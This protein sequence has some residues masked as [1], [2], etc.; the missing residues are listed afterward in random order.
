MDSDKNVVPEGVQNEKPEPTADSAKTQDKNT[1]AIGSPAK[2]QDK[3]I[4]PKDR[5]LLTYGVN[6][7]VDGGYDPALAVKCR[8]GT[9]VG[10]M[11]DGV[12]CFRGIPFA[13]PPTDERRWHKPVPVPDD[14]GVYEAYY[15]GKSPIQTEWK[16]EQASYYPQGED[17]LYLNI[18]VNPCDPSTDKTVMV[19]FHGGAYGWGGTADPMY[20]GANF[21]RAHPDI[22]LVAAAYRTGLMG[23]VDFSKLKGG[24]AFPDAP[25]LGLYDHLESLRWVQ[26]NIAAFGGDPGRVTIFGESAGGGTVSL[27]AMIPQAKG[28]FKRII[29]QSGS[30][31]LTFSK[32]E[33]R[34]FTERLIRES[35]LHDMDSLMRL[36]EEQLIV[37]NA[38]LNFYN[39]FPQRDGR[40]IPLDPY[41]PYRLGAT[42][43]VDILIGTNADE[44]NYWVEE[45]GGIVPF[46]FGIPV[47]F[48]NDLRLLEKDDHTRVKHFL[49]LQKDKGHSIWG[50]AEFYDE[51]MFR[52][53]AVRQAEYHSHNGG[54]VYMYYWTEPSTIPYHGA[55]HA[56]ELS[57]VFGNLDE[58]IYTGAP[59]DPAL[60]AQV[61]EM[62]ANFA[63]TGDPSTEG[64]HWPL[65]DTRDRLTMVLCKE[66]RVESDVLSKQRKLLMPLL[67]YM[68]S[69]SYA[70]LN[71]NMPFVRKAIAGTAALLAGTA[72]LGVTIYKAIKRKQ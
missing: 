9:F 3:K 5:V 69:T 44:S 46:R 50:M 43:D 68:I 26:R 56:V 70:T 51:I 59:S 40:L 61:M 66:S 31:A 28:L 33:C 20:D 42:K 25:N 49:S 53:P 13:L 48:E 17:C 65:Y 37:L 16:T 45:I 34:T 14:D 72:L 60:A 36:S 71:Y 7:P 8:N 19:F 57:Y 38:K 30:V 41:E 64:L 18:W 1:E 32:K 55:C 4:S 29:A 15:N 63:R 2:N 39:N 21:V 12:L 58:T 52:L 6:R 54:R 47:K 27:L 62:W 10:R 11:Q 23:F 24:E 22:V 35:G 67:R